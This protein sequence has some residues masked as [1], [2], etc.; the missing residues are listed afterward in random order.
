M[1]A[2]YRPSLVSERIYFRKG[3]IQGKREMNFRGFYGTR[4]FVDSIRQ[5]PNFNRKGGK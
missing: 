1:R 3:E 4:E 2:Q 5:E